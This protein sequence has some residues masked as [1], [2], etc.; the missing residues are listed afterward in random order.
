MRGFVGGEAHD[1]Y[2]I[3]AHEGDRVEVRLRW[4]HSHGNTAE[5][6]V[7]ESD[8]L[9]S[10]API[11]TATVTEGGRR[12]TGRVGAAGVLYVFVVAHPS[13]HYMLTVR[14]LAAGAEPKASM[15][16]SRNAT[17]VCRSRPLG[18]A[19]AVERP[20]RVAREVSVVF[21]SDRWT[22]SL[23]GCGASPNGSASSKSV[24]SGVKE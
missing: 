5:M 19:R 4:S 21:A 24:R 1:T 18:L 6:T 13:A 7:S 10:A 3:Y 17:R 22:V 16:W 9:G 2:A 11:S 14:R 8:D 23:G 15:K 20:R 12:W